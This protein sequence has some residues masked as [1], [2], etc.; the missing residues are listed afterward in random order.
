VLKSYEGQWKHGQMSADLAVA[1]WY[2]G[3]SY[4]GPYVNGTKHG[5]DG[6]LNYFNM[7][8]NH[9]GNSVVNI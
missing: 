2:S 9:V 6:K 8:L 1:K 3:L 4:V 5:Q 7:Q